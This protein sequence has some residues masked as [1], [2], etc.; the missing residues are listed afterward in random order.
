[1]NMVERTGK[2][3]EAVDATPEPGWKGVLP[4]MLQLYTPLAS[5]GNPTEE[6]KEALA[7]LRDEFQKMAA[8][9]DKYN[10]IAKRN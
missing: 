7:G 3:V 4:L 5:I 1:M 6:H 8:A 9:A 10:E 2:M